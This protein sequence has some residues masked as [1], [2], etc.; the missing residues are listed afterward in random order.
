M[1]ELTEEQL[2]TLRKDFARIHKVITMPA[3]RVVH[4]QG[5]M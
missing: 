2:Q 1:L 4:S 5:L 3:A